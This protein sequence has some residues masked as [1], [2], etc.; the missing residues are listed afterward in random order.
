MVYSDPQVLL[1]E[2]RVFS[3]TFTFWHCKH[4]AQIA[5]CHSDTPFTL[6]K[7]W[8]G[9]HLT[10]TFGHAYTSLYTIFIWSGVH[11]LFLGLMAGF[12]V[13]FWHVWR[14]LCEINLVSESCCR[15]LVSQCR[16]YRSLFPGH[17]LTSRLIHII[18]GHVQSI[19]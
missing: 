1:A 15:K 6:N 4:L 2:D 7:H 18:T 11:G 8:K 19:N 12:N 5:V 10:V 13:E 14:D 3:C 17:R 16:Y 9:H